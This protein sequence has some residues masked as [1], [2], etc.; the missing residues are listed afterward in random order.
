[1]NFDLIYLLYTVRFNRL[2]LIVEFNALTKKEIM[3]N[4]EY[5]LCKINAILSLDYEFADVPA[6]FSLFLYLLKVKKVNYFCQHLSAFS[7]FYLLHF[8]FSTALSPS[9]VSM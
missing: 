3:L 5:L 7:S 9:V 4:Y 2:M 1:M 8:S 6:Y